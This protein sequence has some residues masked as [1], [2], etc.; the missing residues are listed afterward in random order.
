MEVLVV[1]FILVLD[2]ED[3]DS[4]EYEG[5]IHKEMEWPTL[6][7][8]G[9]KLIVEDGTDEAVV[10]DVFHDLINDSIHVECGSCRPHI[11]E[12]AL[13]NIQGWDTSWLSERG[14]EIIEE[15]KKISEQIKSN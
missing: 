1:K 11:V 9:E 5:C 8:V 3:R 2:L 7:R 12:G 6:P 13:S 14:K 15:E 10:T 4:S